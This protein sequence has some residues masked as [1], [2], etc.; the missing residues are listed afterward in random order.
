MSESGSNF[1]CYQYLCCPVRWMFV[2]YICVNEAQRPNIFLHLEDSIYV[3]R[4]FCDRYA[5]IVWLF[6]LSLRITGPAGQVLFGIFFSVV[7]YREY[8]GPEPYRADRRK[9][10][11][12]GGP[13]RKVDEC[14]SGIN[15]Q[16]DHLS[17]QWSTEKTNT[18]LDLA[19]APSSPWCCW[20]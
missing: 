20:V 1:N 18:K 17:I 4:A 13:T 11:A 9:P 8:H 10:L 2:I 14:R 12:L 5:S 3:E 7:E 15:A 16:G 19:G 6:P